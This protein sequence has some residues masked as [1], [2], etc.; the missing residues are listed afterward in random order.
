MKSILAV[1]LF[2]LTLSGCGGAKYNELHTNQSSGKNMTLGVIQKN[3]KVGMSQAEVAASIGSPN[4]VTRDGDGSE[5]W[6]YD[7]IATEQSY[8]QSSGAIFGSKSKGYAAT[9]SRTMTVVIKYD[10]E[11]KVSGMNYHSSQ[12]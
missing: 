12:F 7:K 1:S 9:S 6:I 10:E 2:V 8:S 3:V 11:S 5:T 4:I